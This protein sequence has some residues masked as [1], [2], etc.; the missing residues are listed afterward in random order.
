MAPDSLSHTYG[1]GRKGVARWLYAAIVLY[2]VS[3]I[4]ISVFGTYVIIKGQQVNAQ[5]CHVANDNRNTLVN[6]LKAVRRQALE[7]STSVEERNI[8]RERY[9]ELFAVIP[10][11]ACNTKGVKELEP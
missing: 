7:R 9:N 3:F 4:I 5:L 2:A 8:V 6:I 1:N 11:L 10:P